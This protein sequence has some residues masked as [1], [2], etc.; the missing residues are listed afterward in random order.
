LIVLIVPCFNETHR[1]RLESFFQAAKE[2][3]SLRL[4]FL[5]VDDGSNDGT[6][7]FISKEISTHSESHSCRLVRLE[8]NKGKG[9]AI[10][11][12]AQELQKMDWSRNLDWF[13]YWDADL[14]TPLNELPQFL[15]FLSLYDRVDA[16]WGSRVYRLGSDIRRSALRHY[17]GRGFATVVHHLL[18]VQAYDTQCG[19]KLF[20]KSLLEKIFLKPFI[21]RWIFDIEILLRLRGSL[22]VEYPMKTWHDMPGSKLKIFREIFRVSLDILKIRSQYGRIPSSPLPERQTP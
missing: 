2:M 22:I 13:G 17:L 1:L 18:D 19:A 14:A 12:A 20:R 4:H 10:R 8:K 16:I 3:E 21:S 15:K 5:F 11:Y 6:F 7:D 9:E